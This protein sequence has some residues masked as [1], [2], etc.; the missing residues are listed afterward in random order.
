MNAP[1]WASIPVIVLVLLATRADVRTR[2][3]PNLLTAS[4]L[5]LGVAVH[6]ALEGPAGA[7]NALVGA[8]VA[9]GLLFP[10]WLLRCTGAGDVKL[11][12]AVG[13]WLGHPQSLLA[14]LVSLIAGGVI[15]LVI[16][17]RRGMLAQSVRNAFTLGAWLLSGHPGPKRPVALA[18][19]TRFP[20][21]PAILVGVIFTL[22][23][24]P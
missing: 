15:A 4:A 5:L 8:L 17:L 3:I 2:K 12:A 24:K 23:A 11:M 9:G 1:L 20:F 18:S 21:A 10:G 19:G 13:A 7:G 6:A 14:A 22:M 16:A